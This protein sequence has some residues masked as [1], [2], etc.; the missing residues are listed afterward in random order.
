M[1]STMT[2]DLLSIG[3][4]AARAGLSQKALRLYDRLG[5]LLPARV[6]PATGYR[7][8]RVMQLERARLILLLRELDMPLAEIA[9][10]LSAE[11]GAAQQRLRDHWQRR[12]ATVVKGRRIVTYL[13]G[14]F[15]SAPFEPLRRV[16][17]KT[18]PAQQVLSV[19]RR[20]AIDELPDFISNTID[21]LTHRA[22][23][24]ALATTGPAF[25]V[26]HGPVNAT[27]D[28]PVEIR[29]PVEPPRTAT[30]KAH[31]TVQP[32]RRLAYVT[33]QQDEARFPEILD[34][35]D[36]TWLWVQRRGFHPAG[37][38]ME[39]YA[40]LPGE[41][42]IWEGQVEVAWPYATGRPPPGKQVA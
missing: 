11:P 36:E 38:P 10:L 15:A 37:P 2:D 28:G 25:A 13:D 40:T 33:L 41:D 12:E 19:S 9:D 39:I 4:F 22:A 7:S 16:R 27:C 18:L 34:A 42:V 3:A 24:R 29:L 6:D 14:L 31:C 26:Y 1:A 32:A 17:T 30:A 20:V 23:A 5:L 8:Y 35:Y 21:D